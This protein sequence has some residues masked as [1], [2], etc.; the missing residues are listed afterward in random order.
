MALGQL[1]NSL[2]FSLDTGSI[3]NV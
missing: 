1:D 3:K 2:V